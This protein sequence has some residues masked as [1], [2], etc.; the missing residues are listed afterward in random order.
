MQK[1]DKNISLEISDLNQEQ[2]RQLLFVQIW[3]NSLHFI[4]KLSVLMIVGIMDFAMMENVFVLKDMR[5]IKIVKIRKKL[6]KIS[7]V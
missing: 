1:V 4:K 7:R 6:R 5:R 3:I 2:N